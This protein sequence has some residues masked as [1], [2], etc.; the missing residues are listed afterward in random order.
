MKQAVF[1][2]ES[3]IGKGYDIIHIY[4]KVYSKK[5]FYTLYL[6]YKDWNVDL[7][8]DCYDKAPP[9][10]LTRPEFDE[11]LS[12]YELDESFDLTGYDPD[13]YER[14]YRDSPNS[15]DD[16]DVIIIHT[17]R[18]EYTISYGVDVCHTDGCDIIGNSID[19]TYIG[20]KV[21]NI[22]KAGL[23]SKGYKEVE[24]FGDEI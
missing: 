13:N 18:K 4:Y 10:Y 11:M 6:N 3:K 5:M 14:F 24:T 1:Y 8:L 17:K 19:S 12:N 7:N 2:T 9:K 15:L 16:V 20:D 22:I 23:K 21:F